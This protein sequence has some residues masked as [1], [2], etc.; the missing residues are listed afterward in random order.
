M[1]A[2]VNDEFSGLSGAVSMGANKASMY[3]LTDAIDVHA[4]ARGHDEG[5]AP[6]G[7][8]GQ[9]RGNEALLFKSISPGRPWKSLASSGGRRPLG[10]EEG[11]RP[12]KCLSAW[13][14]GIRSSPSTSANQTAVEAG[15]AGCGCPGHLGL[16]HLPPGRGV[17]FDK[18]RT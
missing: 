11:L 10:R 3:D 14:V 4:H 2:M 15:S 7:A 16:E 9:P 6:R 1:P 13:V 18:T 8:G 12:V 5:A 17:W